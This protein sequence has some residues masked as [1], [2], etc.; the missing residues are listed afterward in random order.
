[1]YWIICLSI[2]DHDIFYHIFHNLFLIFRQSVSHKWLYHRTFKLSFDQLFLRIFQFS[3]YSTSF[4]ESLNHF[5]SSFFNA[6]FLKRQPQHL[7]SN[8]LKRFLETIYILFLSFINFY[9][10]IFDE[11]INVQ[12]LV[13]ILKEKM[14]SKCKP[15]FL[16]ENRRKFL[17]LNGLCFVWPILHLKQLLLLT[18]VT[19]KWLWLTVF[20]K[21]LFWPMSATKIRNQ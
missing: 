6:W 12:F 4:F 3:S 1:M 7:V 9:I 14:C 16:A 2:T 15:Q 19:N 17:I 5:S 21:C 13:I 8:N 20:K 11:K 10:W 18:L